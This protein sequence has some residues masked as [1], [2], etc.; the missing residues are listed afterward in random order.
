VVHELFGDLDAPVR[1]TRLY[2][3]D[4]KRRSIA[5]GVSAQV[6]KLPYEVDR[7]AQLP[8]QH[9]VGVYLRQYGFDLLGE[10]LLGVTL[11]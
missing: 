7:P 4:F 2:I 5:R 10:N 1:L 9:L 3:N 6:P 11:R 8:W